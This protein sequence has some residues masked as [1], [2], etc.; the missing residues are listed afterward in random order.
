MS[1]KYYFISNVWYQRNQ[2]HE[3]ISIIV[4][5][6]FSKLHYTHHNV[7]IYRVV[8]KKGYESVL[9]KSVKR[10]SKILLTESFYTYTHIFKLI[11]FWQFLTYYTW[12]L[13][14]KHIY[15]YIRVCQILGQIKFEEEYSVIRCRDPTFN[16]KSWKKNILSSLFLSPTAV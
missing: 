10:N 7:Y 12:N 2:V 3:P 16:I 8:Q 6:G 14:I 11:I 5:E 4:N 15:V 1:T 13:K 9:R